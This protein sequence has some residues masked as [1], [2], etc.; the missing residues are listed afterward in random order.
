MVSEIS[1][2]A[3]TG[4][5][6]PAAPPTVAGSIAGFLYWYE[7]LAGWASLPEPP[8]EVPL[9][10]AFHLAIQWLNQSAEAISGHIELTI[11][12]PDGAKVTPNDVLNQDNWAAPGHG[13]AVQFETVVLGQAGTYKATATLSAT[14]QVLDE[15]IL[16]VAI[17]AAPVLNLGNALL[18]HSI[19]GH[20]FSE[21]GIDTDGLPYATL[22]EQIT[23]SKL[24][25]VTIQFTYIG[26]Q[27]N[28]A[29][30]T[31][32]LFHLWHQTPGDPSDFGPPGY[33]G[34]YP[35]PLGGCIDL[36]CM[37][38]VWADSPW[39]GSASVKSL[40]AAGYYYP[41]AYD[42]RI[43][44]GLE[45]YDM[46]MSGPTIA[47]FRVKNAIICTGSGTIQ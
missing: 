18:V 19:N 13:W 11:T 20:Q 12:K 14:G 17:V 33:R 46:Y 25:G 36:H 7:G 35:A 24:E 43:A 31:S 27:Q 30:Y 9:G 32:L 44:F 45:Y 10:T 26:G 38:R 39:S 28:T 2:F 4:Y 16:N 47:I 37:W 34:R 6:D 29:S 23:M 22:A 15:E 41:R 5:H 1:G 21:M 42:L 8:P 3:I 40:F